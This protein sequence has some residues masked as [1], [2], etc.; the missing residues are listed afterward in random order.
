MT[1]LKRPSFPSLSPSYYYRLGH[2]QVKRHE[3][4]VFLNLSFVKKNL[5]HHILEQI[6]NIFS[7]NLHPI[8]NLNSIKLKLRF[9]FNLIKI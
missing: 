8:M 4:Y 2:S 3:K 6:F 9:E 1:S 5:K 7:I